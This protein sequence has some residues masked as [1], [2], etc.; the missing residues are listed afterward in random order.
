[1]TNRM[2]RLFSTVVLAAVAAVGQTVA[3]GRIAGRITDATG[4]ALH[5]VRVR[6]TSGDASSEAIT[7]VDGR[8]VVRSL[9]LA[10]HRVETEL[11]GFV[12]R[13]GDIRLSPENRRAYV[14][15][16]L[17]IGCLDEGIRVILSVR[18]AAPVVDAIVHVR[19][20]SADGPVLMSM[21]PECV[22]SVLQEYSVVVLG[23]A[24]AGAGTVGGGTDLQMFLSPDQPGLEPGGEYVAFLW[25]HGRAAD[26]LVIPIR[27]GRVVSPAAGELGGMRPSEALAALSSWSR[28]RGG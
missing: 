27:S 11:L 5:G 20:S 23:S 14:A 13:S 6:I 25:P 3:D 24:K 12:S 19:V 8:F 15:W 26:R 16:R 28:K 21:R 17:E 18:Q 4:A 22:G 10:T 9:P 1:M 7:G 2:G